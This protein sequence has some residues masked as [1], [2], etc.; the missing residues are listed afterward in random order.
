MRLFGHV[1]RMPPGVPA[2]DALRAAV[3]VRCGGVPDPTW[4]RPRG[5]PR[6]TWAEQLRGDLGG[7][8]L[9]EAWDL[10]RDREGWRGFATSRCCSS[11]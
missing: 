4:R 6:M 8:G 10:A 1:A 7:L 11:V 5:R 2:H 3:E 9:R